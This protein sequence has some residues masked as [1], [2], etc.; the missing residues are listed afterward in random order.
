MTQ[1]YVYWTL[2]TPLV[3]IIGL[4][5]NVDGTLDGRGRGDQQAWFESQLAAAAKG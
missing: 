4:Y 3:N 2:D 1:P 5:S